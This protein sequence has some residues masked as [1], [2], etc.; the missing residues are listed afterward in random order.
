M[1]TPIIFPDV[2][3]WATGVLRAA[4]PTYGYPTTG[5]TRTRVSTKYAGGDS[6]V[7]VR[8]DGGGEI[9][10]VRE[11]PRL[12]LNVYHRADTDQ[13]V[14][15]LA[16]TCAAILRAAADGAPV[17]RVVQVVGPSPVADVIPRRFMSFE[18][19]TRGAT[20]APVTP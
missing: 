6:E 14:R 13:P 4:L 11:A 12:A 9:D 15:D 2:E 18:L 1:S 17:L 20:L 16:L 3:L 5:G 7:V 10:Q 19:N 8:R